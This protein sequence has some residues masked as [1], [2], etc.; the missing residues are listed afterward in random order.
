MNSDTRLIDREMQE[1]WLVDQA[2]LGLMREADDSFRRAPAGSDLDPFA[3][4]DRLGLTQKNGLTPFHVFSPEYLAAYRGSRRA[5]VLQK[6][7]LV[8]AIKGLGPEASEGELKSALSEMNIEVSTLPSSRRAVLSS[9]NPFALIDGL[10]DAPVKPVSWFSLQWAQAILLDVPNTMEILNA[11]GSSTLI[12]QVVDAHG[13]GVADAKVVLVFNQQKRAGIEDATDANGFVTLSTPAGQAVIDA[14]A[15][16]PKHSHWNFAQT[17]WTVPSGTATISL[18]PLGQGHLGQFKYLGAADPAAGA[19][20]RC[21][22]VDSGVGPH[23]ALQV[24]GGANFLTAEEEDPQD[25]GSFKDNGTG[26]G[27]HVA[28]IISAKDL[29][30]GQPFGI[31]PAVELFSYRVT[32]RLA[33][34]ASSYAIEDAINAAVKQDCHLINLSLGLTYRDEDVEAA[35]E[36]AYD[37]GCV[38]IA[39]VGND[40]SSN[41]MFPAASPK[42]IGV[43]ALGD[44]ARIAKNTMSALAFRQP[45]TGIHADDFV[46]NFNSQGPEVKVAAPGVGIISCA[47]GGQFYAAEDGTSM[48][49]PVI[50]GYAAKLLASRQDILTMQG[51]SRADAICKLV[52]ETCDR[53][54]FPMADVGNGHPKP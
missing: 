33:R 22:V 52:L 18:Q 4:L 5:R 23:P 49:T 50:T 6:E 42:T 36:R 41:I 43:A 27:T 44:K 21:G 26:H 28:G 39:A 30:N 20:V 38:V 14:I 53:L 19:G 45:P 47:P 11:A 31:A 51:K 2:W 25:V 29:G 24:S 8:G 17:R 9:W 35:V 34:E 37:A 7:D 32:A 16:V 48:A 15:V 13:V 1:D 12:M 3:E 40:P 54:G 10:P 46:A